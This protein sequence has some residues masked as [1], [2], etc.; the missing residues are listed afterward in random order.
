MCVL[1][2]QFLKMSFAPNSICIPLNIPLEVRSFLETKLFRL[3]EFIE[4]EEALA[5]QKDEEYSNF[6][7]LHQKNY[8]EILLDEIKDILAY[9]VGTNL[10]GKRLIIIDN[11]HAL[12]IPAHIEI[13]QKIIFLYSCEYRSDYEP[14]T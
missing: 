7:L 5:S 14:S 13:A 6:D 4:I 10:R 2:G 1:Y 11:S 9:N 12:F 3:E 8:I